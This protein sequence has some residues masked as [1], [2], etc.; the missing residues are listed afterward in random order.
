MGQTS[1]NLEFIWIYLILLP[2]MAT[3]KDG[4]LWNIGQFGPNPVGSFKDR[5]WVQPTDSVRCNRDAIS[6]RIWSHPPPVGHRRPYPS[7]CGAGVAPNFPKRGLLEAGHDSESSVTS[8]VMICPNGC[9]WKWLVPLNPMVLLII[10]PMKNGYFIGNIPNI[11]RQTQIITK[12]IMSYD[13]Q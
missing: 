12:V 8:P 1:G 3:S 13:A 10:I 2:E 4:S 6:P 7:L 9:V 11:F 5:I